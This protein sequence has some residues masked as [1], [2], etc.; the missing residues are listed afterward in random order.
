[1]NPQ[2]APSDW[3]QSP[4]H[5][6]LLL[7]FEKPRDIKQVFDWEWPRQEL[8]EKT[9]DVIKRFLQEGMLVPA[10][11]EEGLNKLFQ[12]DQLKR[13]LS[14]R[15]LPS[16]GRKAE[17]IERL[18]S[19]DRQGMGKIVG[20]SIVKCSEAALLLI[21]ERKQ[22]VERETAVAERLT[23]QAFQSLN[24]KEACRIYEAF[25]RSFIH[26]T[27]KMSVD[28][29]ADL[30]FILTG[31]PKILSRLSPENLKAL[32]LATC[33]KTLWKARTTEKWLPPTFTSPF[34][35]NDI[36]TNYLVRHAEYQRYLTGLRGFA[37]QVKVSFH[38]GDIESCNLCVALDGQVFDIGAVPELPIPGCTS[39]TGCMLHLDWIDED[40]ILED[41]EEGEEIFSTEL[42]DENIALENPVGTLRVLKQMLDE[43]LITQAEYDEKKKKILSRL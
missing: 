22:K 4:A 27:Y 11:V 13:L 3:K 20:N 19:H 30:Q 38:M 9:E 34:K 36:P 1:M 7:A 15:G 6:G 26:S 41:D 33:M 31:H 43:G 10:S 29:V 37:K 42:T 18:V 8:G 21:D 2:S 17:L 25:R 12:V 14:E 24:P 16:S 5:I 40:E 39:E 35:N 28:S 32:Q 23:Y